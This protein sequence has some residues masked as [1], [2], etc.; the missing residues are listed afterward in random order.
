MARTDFPRRT[1]RRQ[2]Q[3]TSFAVT[4]I[5]VAK[6]RTAIEIFSPSSSMVAGL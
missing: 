1:G 2:S 3:V 6:R 5:P 4:L